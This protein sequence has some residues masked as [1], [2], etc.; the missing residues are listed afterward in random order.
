MA[1]HKRMYDMLGY[2]PVNRA[3]G[4]VEGALAKRYNEETH[5]GIGKVKI[6]VPV[7]VKP[8]RTHMESLTF[9]NNP[10]IHV[11]KST[12]GSAYSVPWKYLFLYENGKSAAPRGKNKP[13][14]PLPL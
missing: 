4:E 8:G 10:F 13:R 5:G 9:M 6:L 3:P 12:H 7:C 2:Y 14:P 11:G 1:V